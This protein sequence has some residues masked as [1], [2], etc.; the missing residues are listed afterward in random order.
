MINENAEA[1]PEQ[2]ITELLQFLDLSQVQLL[3]V[4]NEVSMQ[5]EDFRVLVQTLVGR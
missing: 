1:F 5:M 3:G 2:G 4:K